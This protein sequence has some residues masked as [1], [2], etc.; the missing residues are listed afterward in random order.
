MFAWQL[1]WQFGT[2]AGQKRFE[3]YMAFIVVFNAFS[4]RNGKVRKQS[5]Q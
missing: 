4:V 3:A 5:L 2:G 1:D